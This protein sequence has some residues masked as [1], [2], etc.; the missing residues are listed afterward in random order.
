MPLSSVELGRFIEEEGVNTL[1]LAV[2]NVIDVYRDRWDH[3]IREEIAKQF[4][5]RSQQKLRYLTTRELNILK[6]VVN[7]SALVYKTPATR[8]ALI[9]KSEVDDDGDNVYQKDETY[10]DVI[11]QNKLNTFMKTANKYTELLNQSLVHVCWRDGK[12][13]YDLINFDNAEIY[14]DPRDWKKIIGVKYYVNLEI[15]SETYADG[16]FRNEEELNGVELGDGYRSDFSY[17]FLWTLEDYNETTKKYES[18][19]FRKYKSADGEPVMVEENDNPYRDMN[20]DL[21]LPFVLLWRQHPVD[22]LMDFSTGNDLFDGN[23]NI[24]LN[25]VHLNEL[26]KYQSY[27]QIWMKVKSRENLPEA[28]DLDPQSIITLEDMDGTADIGTLD[29]QSSIDTVWKVIQSRIIA[30]LGTRGISPNAI[31]LSS[32]PQSGIALKID[33][34]P[35]LE[36]RQDDI[37]IYREKEDEIFQLMRIVNNT[38]NDKKINVTAEL[39]IDFGEVKFPDDPLQVR[40]A[41]QIDLINN[42]LTPV[43]IIMKRNPDLEREE[44]EEVW[45]LNKGINASNSGTGLAPTQQPGEA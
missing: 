2:R 35:I 37:E 39:R 45:Q 16:T 24:A 34:M 40:Q 3:I 8:E 1:K 19:K 23:L 26:I 7:E 18:S 9:E 21:V 10:Q 27:K 22:R 15:P 14:T 32:S 17:M 29:I 38:Y 12:L 11:N 43:D 36:K 44:A 30:M 42:V 28:M 5:P 13:D 25:M 4:S 6:K 41:E 33:K 20:G 31:Q